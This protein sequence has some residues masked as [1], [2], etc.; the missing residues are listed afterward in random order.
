M[1]QRRA[2][3]IRRANPEDVGAAALVYGYPDDWFADTA[4][5]SMQVFIAEATD[6]PVGVIVLDG[7]TIEY[8]YVDK[9]SR[10]KGLGRDLITLVAA[11]NPAG[12]R[13]NRTDL[14]P[15]LQHL[16][17]GYGFSCVEGGTYRWPGVE[18]ST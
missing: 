13:V 4:L 18:G 9:A 1:N 10:K 8:I 17:E 15:E 3:S 6:H 12:L 16:L 14:T 5:V 11:L 2:F 7:S